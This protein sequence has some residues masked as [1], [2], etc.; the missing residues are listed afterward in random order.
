MNPSIR[1]LIEVA[2]AM[3]PMRPIPDACQ[4]PPDDS[5]FRCARKKRETPRFVFLSL[6]LGFE[7]DTLEIALR[8]HQG[9]LDAILLSEATR[10]HKNMKTK[11]MTW[12]RIRRQP[13]FRF[14]NETKVYYGVVDDILLADELFSSDTNIWKTESKQNEMLQ[15]QSQT[16]IDKLKRDGLNEFAHIT[17]NADEVLSRENVWKVKW[18]DDFDY[19]VLVGA[20]WTPMGDLQHAFRVDH[21]ALSSVPYGDGLVNIGLNRVVNVRQL[22][23]RGQ[24]NVEGMVL[25]GGMHMTDINFWAFRVLKQLTATEYP[26]TYEFPPIPYTHESFI[27]WYSKE[28]QKERWPGRRVNK[29]QLVGRNRRILHVPWFLAC[30]IKRYPYWEGEVDPRSAKVF[31]RLR[32]T[33]RS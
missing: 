7:T 3:E 6:L 5:S 19:D 28:M 17:A 22:F 31:Q 25:F 20:L 18:C 10:Q 29:E 23:S 32:R 12:H 24:H 11:H 15:K 8:E 4:K 27:R 2:N 14:L 21:P 26:G 1:E 9:L 30:A 16:I 13:R 33:F